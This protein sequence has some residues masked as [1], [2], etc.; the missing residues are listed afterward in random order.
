MFSMFNLLN[1]IYNVI[2]LHSR[3]GISS[4]FQFIFYEDTIQDLG[5]KRILRELYV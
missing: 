5:I 3:L 4:I 1:N 2:H